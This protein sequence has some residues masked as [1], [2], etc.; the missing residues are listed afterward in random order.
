MKSYDPEYIL[1]CRCTMVPSNLDKRLDT[2]TRSQLSRLNRRF[3][4]GGGYKFT[5]VQS[6][7][8]EITGEWDVY[9]STVHESLFV[10]NGNK[11][12]I[13]DTSG[14]IQLDWVSFYDQNHFYEHFEKCSKEE[15]ER[16]YSTINLKDL[17]CYVNDKHRNLNIIECCKCVKVPTGAN[18]PILGSSFLKVGA[19]FYFTYNS[20]D[21]GIL[22]YKYKHG[23][24]IDRYYEV[25]R[26]PEDDFP[27]FNDYFIKV[28]EEDYIKGIQREAIFKQFDL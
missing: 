18:D 27:F 4:V 10:V 11:L 22:L 8:F 20:A 17:R 23:L 3:L 24:L 6:N 7:G 5:F 12:V 2:T 16:S 19:Y 13:S 9:H 21:G 15:Y 26:E 1:Y 25:R 14:K 28:H